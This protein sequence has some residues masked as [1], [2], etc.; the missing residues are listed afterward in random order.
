MAKAGQ[1]FY[2]VW[3]GIKPGVYSTWKECQGQVK[4]FEDAKFMSFPNEKQA[5]F[6]FKDKKGMWAYLG[7]KKAAT[8][9]NSNN[10]ASVG[11]PVWE[12]ISVDAACSGNPGVMEYQGVYTKT[13][14]LLFHGGPYQEATNNV[15]E[16]LALVHVLAMLKQQNK[17][18]PVYSDSKTAMAWVKRK[19]AKTKLAPTIRNKKVFDLIARA[20]IWLKTNTWNVPILKWDTKNWG[21]IPADFGRK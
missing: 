12:S 4:G 14:K 19:H 10:T 6:A 9:A 7:K 17:K 13:G 16:F 5:N 1:K 2:V 3:K 20:E 21:E 8:R 11:G 18:L 15:G